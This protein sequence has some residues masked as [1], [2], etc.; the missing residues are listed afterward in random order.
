MQLFCRD[1]SAKK[2]HARRRRAVSTT[3]MP[4]IPERAADP[5][6]GRDLVSAAEPMLM[7]LVDV[8]ADR[9]G[10][11]QRE[12]LVVRLAAQGLSNKEAS[13]AIGCA[14]PTIS[15]YWQRI[16]RKTGL[17][18]PLQLLAHLLLEALGPGLP[19]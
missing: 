4:T 3:M 1:R 13:F 12:R 16:R 10:L 15:I 19:P 5:L 6:E 2:L 8:F 7:A 14:I 11:S 9:H 17:A 18:S